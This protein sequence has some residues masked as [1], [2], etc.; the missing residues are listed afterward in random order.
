MSVSTSSPTT[1]APAGA[2]SVFVGSIIA[3][4]VILALLGIGIKRFYD[5]GQFAEDK[6]RPLTQWSVIKFYLG[7]LA[8]TLKVAAVAMVIA[9]AIGGLMALAR[10]ARAA[11]VRWLATLYVEFFRGMALYLLILFCWLGLPRLGVRLDVFW[12]LVIGLSVYNSAVS[13]RD[14]AG[15]HPLARPG[16]G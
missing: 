6:W 13:G 16:P 15:R 3:G 8:N 10:L 5:N 1:S 9:L 11:P 4:I 14:P 12:Y 2:A 7:G